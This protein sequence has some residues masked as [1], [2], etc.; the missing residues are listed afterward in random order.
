MIAIILRQ[1]GYAC[2][3]FWLATSAAAAPAKRERCFLPGM[4][5][6][7]DCLTLTVPLD[8]A[9][10][11][12]DKIRIFAAVLPA[13]SRDSAHDAF[14]LIPGGPGQ[15]GDSLI[16]LATG[17][18]RDIRQS[19]DI[20]LIYPRGTAR[21]Q[22]LNCPALNSDLPVSN[23]ETM[24]RVRTCAAD[25][26]INTTYF[27]SAEIVRDLEEVRR[28]LGYAQLSLWGGS[29][30]SRIVQHYARDYPAQTRLAILDAA[31][32][33]G[34]SIVETAPLAA[35][36][37][38]ASIDQAC[39]KDSACRKTSPTLATDIKSL[40]ANFG[41]DYR[42]LR[43]TD[44]V[45]GRVT[46][47][48]VNRQYLAGTIHLTLYNPQTRALL[49]QLIA[50][51]KQGRFEPLLAMG[52]ASGAALDDQI[53]IGANFS[54]LCAEDMQIMRAGNRASAAQQSFMGTAQRDQLTDICTAWPHAKIATRFTRPFRSNVPT[55]ILSGAL[56]PIT[57]PESGAIAASY[58]SKATHVP[59]PASSHISSTF[60]CAPRQ[61]AKFVT[62]GRTSLTD[63]ACAQKARPPAP[64]GTPNG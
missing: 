61:I 34:V 22:P 43:I 29:F 4:E 21:S 12:A 10:P 33:V 41:K 13:L 49:P 24:K 26:H 45:T 63:W 51:A 2:A 19:R 7:A 27:T 64:L 59:L 18:F 62:D 14:V 57:P 36:A 58:F 53:S 50:A 44:P 42:A 37:A 55:L 17:A 1:I 15:S 16:N 5:D 31:A 25:R 11:A 46:T 23:A 3:L 20:V 48:Q 39:R 40:L 38:L 9:R 47:S 8:W 60:G 32:P 56:D 35:E 30:G 28:S 52:A 54:A 6:A